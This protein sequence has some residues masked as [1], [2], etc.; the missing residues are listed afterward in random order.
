MSTAAWITFAV[1]AGY[2]WG[3]FLVL[4]ALA[5]QKERVKVEEGDAERGLWVP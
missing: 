2:V 4:L 3:G 1:I 5:F